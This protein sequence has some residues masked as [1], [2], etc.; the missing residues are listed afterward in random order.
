MLLERVLPKGK[1]SSR[2][3]RGIDSSTLGKIQDFCNVHN[4]PEDKVI[5]L[6]K[7]ALSPPPLTLV[8]MPLKDIKT[9]VAIAWNKTNYTQLKE[10]QEWKIYHKNTGLSAAKRLTWEH[11]FR[12]WVELP[13]EEKNLTSGYGVINGIDIFK[14][15]RPWEVFNVDKNTGTKQDIQSAFKKLSFKYH[16][17]TGYN[18]GDRNIFEKLKEMRD[19]L[20]VIFN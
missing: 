4:C 1:K 8:E 17:D 15:F 12:E 2:D 5:E 3:P 18:G 10:D 14:N 16:P 9:A 19:S 13:G 7:F 6:I 11:Y 20:L